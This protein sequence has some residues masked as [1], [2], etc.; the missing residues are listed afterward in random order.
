[1]VHLK[2]SEPGTVQP[3]PRYGHISKIAPEFVP[4]QA[5]TDADLK[6]LWELPIDEFKHAWKTTPPALA[7]DAPVPGKDFQIIHQLVPVKDGKKIEIHIYKPVEPEPEAL[8]FLNA[9][10]EVRYSHI[11]INTRH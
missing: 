8:L 5:E 11:Q 10:G 9:M 7:K 1:M 4:L 3:K 6:A 2:P